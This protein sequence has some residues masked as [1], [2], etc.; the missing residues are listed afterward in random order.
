MTLWRI[1]QAWINKSG[2]SASQFEGELKSLQ[3]QL[4]GNITLDSYSNIAERFKEIKSEVAASKAGIKDYKSELADIKLKID[5]GTFKSQIDSIES[6]LKKIGIDKDALSKN[7]KLTDEQKAQKRVVDNTNRLNDLYKTM[8]SSSASPEQK[9]NAYKEFNTVLGTTRSQLSSVVKAESEFAKNSKEV[10]QAEITLTKSKTLSNNIQAWM[11]Q[12]TKAADRFGDELREL[13]QQLNENK[14]SATLKN[15]QLE[16]AKVKSEAKAAGLTTNT[17]LTNLKNIGAQLLGL[18]STVAIVQKAIEIAKEMY[19]NVYE[20]DTAM[21]NLKKVT[22]ESDTAYS[23]FFSRTADSAKNLGRT[24][25]GLITQTSEWAKLGYSLTESEELSKLSSIYANVGE[26][27]DETAVSDMVT[28]LKAYNIDTDDAVK[29]VDIYNELGN[30]FAISSAKLGEGISRS[31]SALNLAGASIEQSSAMLTG[32]AE[33]T[34]NAPEAGNALKVFTMRI[35]GMKGELEELGEEV[36]PTVDSISKVQTQIL[37]LTKGKVN[38]FDSTGS[39]RNYYDIMKEI[40]DI[41]DELS[42]TDKASLLEILFGKQ[43]GNAGSALIQAF[44]SGQVEKALETA[45]NSAGSAMAEQEKWMES[46]EAKTSQLKA[47]WEELSQVFMDSDFLKELVDTGT[48]FLSILS[49]IVE[50]FGT[51]PSLVTAISAITSFKNIGKDRM[52]SFN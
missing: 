30:K 1:R 36:D 19:Q 4:K 44:Q 12:N 24:I 51:I 17:F 37:N 21:T 33:I 32:I 3:K 45:N 9:V 27:D 26:V 2:E 34:Q 39:F 52:F 35:R 23:K 15:A 46:L 42:S 5:I 20:I 48:N 47:A 10:E 11:N 49:S 29:I 43:R 13:Q 50:K 7:D 25:S 28:A 18:T 14:D 8:T 40:A 22:D 38:I 16:F 31:A 6:A 41:Y